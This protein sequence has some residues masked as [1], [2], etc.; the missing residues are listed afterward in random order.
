MAT[1]DVVDRD[2]YNR[3]LIIEELFRADDRLLEFVFNPV[4]A[5]LRTSAQNLIKEGRSLSSGEQLLIR[6]A[7]DIWSGEG[8]A[9]VGDLLTV[10]DYSRF[11]DVIWAMKS[12]RWSE[13]P[14]YRRQ[15]KLPTQQGQRR[16]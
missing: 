3:R 12:A 8:H 4:K 10:I 16:Q 11:E 5:E 7:L 14:E 2:T 1:W 6:V 13:T 15:L 9:T